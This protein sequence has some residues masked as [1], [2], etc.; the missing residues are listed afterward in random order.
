MITIVSNSVESCRVSPN[1][2]KNKIQLNTNIINYKKYTLMKKVSI[3][4][5]FILITLSS[6]AEQL[7]SEL[8]YEKEVKYQYTRYD[9]GNGYTNPYNTNNDYTTDEMYVQR[10]ES[11]FEVETGYMDN[12]YWSASWSSFSH[13][14]EMFNQLPNYQIFKNYMFSDYFCN[15]WDNINKDKSNQDERHRFYQELRMS[16]V[17][18][19]NSPADHSVVVI[20]LI[21]VLYFT[22]KRLRRVKIVVAKS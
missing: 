6:A 16:T 14:I 10:I 3:L 12:P 17:A 1:F 5:L 9:Q 20:L 21:G 22:I 7:P 8:Y 19:V 13:L 15:F 18:P 4:F 2:I 11:Y